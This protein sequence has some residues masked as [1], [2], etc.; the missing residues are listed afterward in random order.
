LQAMMK[1]FRENPPTTLAGAAVTEVKDYETLNL[2]KA[3]GTKEKLNFPT[4]SNVLQWFTE[5]NSKISVRPSGTEPKIKFYMEVS[6]P[7]NSPEE[8]DAARVQASAK[9]EALKK[10]LGI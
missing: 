6:V 1:N 8:Y 3:D 2:T 10:D 9:I 7:M 5:D 4:T